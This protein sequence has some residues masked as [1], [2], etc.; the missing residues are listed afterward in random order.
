MVK[1]LRGWQLEKEMKKPEEEED[2]EKGPTSNLATALLSLWAHGKVSGR[3]MRWLAECAL[4]DGA[5]H[6]DLVSIAKC[7]SHG[8]HPGNIHRDLMATFCKGIDLPEG[9]AVEVA[10]KILKP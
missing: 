9:F 2:L 3:T 6:D 1:R 4:L 7:G 10:C 5:Q 8:V